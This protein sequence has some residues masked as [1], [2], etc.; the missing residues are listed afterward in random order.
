[1]DVVG[2]LSRFSIVSGGVLESCDRD[3]WRKHLNTYLSL[4]EEDEKWG[5]PQLIGK[6]LSHLSEKVLQLVEMVVAHGLRAC[7]GRISYDQVRAPTFRRGHQKSVIDY[8][9]MDVWLWLDMVDMEVLSTTKSDHCPLAVSL[10]GGNYL[11]S[12]ARK[13]STLPEPSLSSNQRQVTWP[14]VLA[15]LDTHAKIY[16]WCVQYVADPEDQPVDPNHY[17]QT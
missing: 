13:F 16:Q 3:V 12:S 2:R 4:G 10:N 17:L 1:M 6:P 8:I 15:D 9:L 5:A 14:R 11:R 7:N